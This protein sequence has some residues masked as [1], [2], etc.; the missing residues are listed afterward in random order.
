MKIIEKS[1]NTPE[2]I[3]LMNE[4]SEILESITGDSGK[5]SFNPNDICGSN[6]VFVIA[7]N[8]NE[9]AIG[10]GAIR[11]IDEKTAEVK[12]MYAKTKAK[13]VGTEILCYL[14]KRAQE[15]GYSVLRLETRLVNKRAVSFYESRG[16]HRILNY[17]KYVNKPE[18]ICFE[19]S[20]V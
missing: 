17:G 7:Y 4:L 10:C 18:A 5:S 9:E 13:G 15:I 1:S 14:E 2:A 3:L 12:R 16:Y 6:A 8:Q 20:I 11:P 19:K